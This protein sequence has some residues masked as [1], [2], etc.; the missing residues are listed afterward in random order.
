[1]SEQRQDER[2]DNLRPNRNPQRTGYQFWIVIALVVV[3]VWYHVH[4]SYECDRLYRTSRT[5]YHVE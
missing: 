5:Q 1:M 2:Q 4:R 3:V